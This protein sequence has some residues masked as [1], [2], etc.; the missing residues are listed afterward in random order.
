MG[1]VTSNTPDADNGFLV[2]SQNAYE[3]A[4]DSIPEYMVT[5]EA[6]EYRQTAGT[7]LFKVAASGTAGTD[8]TYTT[9]LTIDNGADVYTTAWTDYGGS[10]TVVGWSSSTKTVR[11]KEIGNMVF[12]SFKITGT[13]NATNATFTVP[14]ASANTTVD[15]GGPL[16]VTV[17]NGATATEPGKATLPA[18][19]S[20]VTCLSDTASATWTAS[21]TKTV[22]GSFFYEKA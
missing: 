1:Y 2:S 21:G 4:A 18:N 20:T 9:A 8:I 22:E 6:S 12:V 17:D 10:S 14:N 15:F 13:S 5:D 16:L 19:S 7:H 3:A 11:Y